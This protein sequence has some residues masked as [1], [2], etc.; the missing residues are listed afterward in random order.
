MK[1]ASLNIYFHYWWSNFSIIRESIRRSVS[2]TKA[3]PCF[4]KIDKT[5]KDTSIASSVRKVRHCL[6]NQPVFIKL[7]LKH[8]MG[9]DEI[10]ESLHD[11]L[12]ECY[13]KV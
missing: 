1:I 11:M 2:F 3:F 7:V 12:V 6:V 4:M 5:M 10:D 8:L 9:G 13:F